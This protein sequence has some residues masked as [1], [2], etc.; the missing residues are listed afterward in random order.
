MRSIDIINTLNPLLLN[1][2]GKTDSISNFYVYLND[3]IIVVRDKYFE[4]YGEINFKTHIR[5]I[6]NIVRTCK[7]I[8]VVCLI[9]KHIITLKYNHTDITK[10]LKEMIK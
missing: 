1:N 10:K 6:K 7:H 3:D 5:N 8:R 2:I 9:K 4:S